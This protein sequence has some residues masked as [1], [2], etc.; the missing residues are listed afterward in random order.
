[1]LCG[2]KRSVAVGTGDPIQQLCSAP[3][4]GHMTYAPSGTDRAHVP[5]AAPGDMPCPHVAHPH[6]SYSLLPPMQ[7]LFACPEG[8]GMDPF[9][10]PLLFHVPCSAPHVL[11]RHLPLL[12]AGDAAAS[13]TVRFPPAVVFSGVVSCGDA[14]RPTVGSPHWPA[15]GSRHRPTLRSPH[16]PAGACGASAG[17]G[18]RAACV[19]S[20][21]RMGGRP[22]AR[23][24]VGGRRCAPFGPAPAIVAAGHWTWWSGSRRRGE[25]AWAGEQL[26][27]WFEKSEDAGSGGKHNPAGAH[28]RCE[29][30]KQ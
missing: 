3:A 13:S 6:H 25:E 4:P 7:L 16:W 28:I 11:P 14:H 2:V 22:R 17:C 20:P 29:T 30:R 10:T 8:V 12:H 15:A 18:V 5:L 1:M 23:L 19:R 9:C 27:R 24:C 21:G 26:R